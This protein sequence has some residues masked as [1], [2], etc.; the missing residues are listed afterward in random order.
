MGRTN[1]SYN[2]MLSAI[3]GKSLPR[4]TNYAKDTASLSTIF[5][6][7]YSTIN[8][9]GNDSLTNIISADFDTPEEY[10]KET[11]VGPI[12]TLNGDR[13]VTMTAGEDYT[14]LGATADGDEEVTV[15]TSNL[16]TT[17][18]GTY[19]VSYSATD[20]EGY[21]R[22]E[23][24]F[25]KVVA[26]EE[27]TPGYTTVPVTLGDKLHLNVSSLTLGQKYVFDFSQTRGKDFRLSNDGTT[28]LT[29]GV[30][31][32]ENTLVYT[33]PSDFNSPL[34]YYSPNT[35]N[36]G[37]YFRVNNVVYSDQGILKIGGVTSIIRGQTYTFYF[38]SDFGTTIALTITEDGTDFTEDVTTT[39]TSLT[40][41]VPTKYSP[42]AI[43][44]K[45]PTTS[46]IGSSLT[47]SGTLDDGVIYFDNG[48]L[49]ATGITSI[50]RGQTYTF[51]F[52]SDFG[53]TIALSTTEDGTDFTEDVTTTPTSLTFVVPETYGKNII[54]IKSPTTTGIGSSL[55][56][57]G[58]VT[59]N[60][61]Y[62]D[63]T[64]NLQISGVNSI[65]R[66]H[67]YRFYFSSDYGTEILLALTED[68]TT[69]TQ[70]VTTEATSLTF[71][72]P[73][74]Y[75]QNNIYIKSPTTTGIGSSLSVKDLQITE[76]KLLASDGTT[77]DRFGDSVSISRDGLTAIVG[78]P[79]CNDNNN[80]TT[81]AAYIFKYANGSWSEN[82]KLLANV[83]AE[84]DR[85]GFSVSISDDGL[86][87]IVGAPYY[88]GN[89]V[90]TGAAYIFK[91]ANGLWSET[92]LLSQYY[93]GWSVSIS[94]D[95]LTA[96]VAATFPGSVYVFNYANGSW[97]QSTE[98]KENGVASFQFG[99][100][101]SISR[102]GL[103]VI[104]GHPAN[105][106]NGTN[107]GSAYIFK[108]ANG[109]WSQTKLLA[110]DIA[111][112]DQFGSSVSISDDGLTAIVGAWFD[113]YDVN[114]YVN[115]GAAYI[116][117]Y[118]NGTWSQTK[119]L[120]DY[121]T[122]YDYFGSSVSISGD[123][124]TAIVGAYFDDDQ[125]SASGSAFIFKY[126]NGAWSLTKLLASDG[127][128]SD[129]F[130]DSVSISRDGLTAIVGATQNDDNG[131]DSG[132]AYIYNYL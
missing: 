104:V 29:D 27:W 116:F 78:A 57:S 114:G 10:I 16:D 12:I 128:T 19:T 28:E 107:S 22:V 3:A 59:P 86:T 94:G 43:Y 42:N 99:S 123:G 11:N 74:T 50:I 93:F 130:G 39:P 63:A 65:G 45:S 56:V 115:S 61:V 70:G 68:G 15:D 131:T 97:S 64:G 90:N 125:G 5:G 85:F 98:L 76:T 52:S 44:I 87:A 110:N 127:T 132:S 18:V 84:D 37:G 89:S 96:I 34:Y 25:V 71:S 31:E 82:T 9:R 121:P 88:D 48:I 47:V 102:D 46:G 73:S 13:T 55:T 40:F 23:N 7:E 24:R 80:V 106:D 124:L 108:Y 111:A 103:T 81:G 112:D 92:R 21:T 120:A 100:S 26:P 129:R 14:D 109:E 79:Y 4:F 60:H 118:A 53:T 72:V 20:T 77:S 113:D 83:R 117:N 75:A 35:P 49:K 67:T 33:V 6:N 91:Y 1:H 62:F 105:N 36:I 126:D 54:Y 95:G 122:Q 38:S 119:L 17:V 2:G 51:Y 69:F 8:K 30:I 32:A 66:G 101:V 58:A 41:I